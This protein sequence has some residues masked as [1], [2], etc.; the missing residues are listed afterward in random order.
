MKTNYVLIDYENV[1]PS[2][3]ASLQHEHVRVVVFAGPHQTKI[4]LETADAL[5]RMGTNAEYVRLSV[6][7]PNALDFHIAYYLGLYAAKEP[8]AYFHIVTKDTG[9]DPLIQH[10]KERGVQV[11]RVK[12]VGEIPL[13]KPATPTPSPDRLSAVVT[14]LRKRG[15]ARP[16][17]VSTLT[18]TIGDVFGKKL[19]AAEVSSLVSDLKKKG[20]VKVDGTNVTYSLP[21]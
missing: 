9:F 19:T 10:L 16:R 5:Q 8:T 18:S 21:S 7:G 13:P 17:T 20:I 12:T 4:A 14:N 1:Q 6:G 2:D 15:T 3:L 11:R